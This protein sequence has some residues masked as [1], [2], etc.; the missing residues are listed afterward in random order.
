MKCITIVNILA[1]TGLYTF[2]LMMI[3]KIL[4]Y[5][6]WVI[7][8]IRG[9]FNKYHLSV[10]SQMDIDEITEQRLNSKFLVKL[11]KTSREITDM[12]RTV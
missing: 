3:V 2:R 1:V 4:A 8:I 5:R 10:E 7:F 6:Y 11:N 12:L 9:L